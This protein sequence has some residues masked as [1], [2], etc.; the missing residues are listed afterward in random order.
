MDLQVSSLHFDADEKLVSFINGKVQKLEI[1]CDK[2][3]AGQVFLRLDKSSNNENKIAEIKLTIPGRELFA[4]RKCKSFEEAT[5]LACQAL[6]KQVAK[7]K[8]K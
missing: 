6:K 2:I 7:Y 3:I 1:F 4:K 8:D 5:D